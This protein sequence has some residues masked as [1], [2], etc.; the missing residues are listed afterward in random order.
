VPAGNTGNVDVIDTQTGAATA[1]SGFAT[2]E[3]TWRERKRVVGPSS[4]TLGEGV[5]Y[6]GSRA[7]FTVCALDSKTL[8]RGA[9]TQ[10]DTSPDGLAYVASTHEVWVTCPR[11]STVRVLDAAT[12]QQK[13]SLRF[14]GKPEGY[15]VDLQRGR[16][17]MNLEDK[18]LTLAIAL[19]T[20]ATVETWK[21]ACGEEG[22]HGLAL[23]AAAGQLFLA[24]DARI[25]V[26]DVAHGGAV[27]GSLATGPGVDNL[28]VLPAKH[29]VA[30]G[31]AEAGKLT[32]ARYDGAGRMTPLAVVETPKGCRNGVW[33]A[34][35][36]VYL[37]CSAS[38]AVLVVSPEQPRR[39]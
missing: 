21:P 23:D 25:E 7:D 17:Y 8:A 28:D 36:S 24:C 35:S 20:R 15:A 37:A 38:S 39:P 3:V 26:L 2:K 32:V 10:L 12:L 18:D 31:A 9:C 30:A 11:D 33:A 13:A 34:D 14:E 16:F 1:V 29:L 4:A 27:L 22:P 6:V 5:M 19:D